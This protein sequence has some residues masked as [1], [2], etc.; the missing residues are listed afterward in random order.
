MASR[1]DRHIFVTMT[2]ECLRWMKRY[3]EKLDLPTDASL[4]NAMCAVANPCLN[5]G[6]PNY[7]YYADLR[8]LE[9]L[10]CPSPTSGFLASTVTNIATYSALEKFFIAVGT[11]S[12]SVNCTSC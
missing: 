11:W 2:D 1:A 7:G 5:T 10:C 3:D 8:W 9:N 12:K 4:L 6:T